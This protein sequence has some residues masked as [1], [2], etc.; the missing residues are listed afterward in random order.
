MRWRRTK[1]ERAAAPDHFRVLH[2]ACSMGCGRAATT[3]VERISTGESMGRCCEAC[4]PRLAELCEVQYPNDSP[5][6]VLP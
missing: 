1:A 5:F 6:P 4:A 2:V 3:V